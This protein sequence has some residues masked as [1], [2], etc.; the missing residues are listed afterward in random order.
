[1]KLEGGIYWEESIPV[2]EGGK[3]GIYLRCIYTPIKISK[4]EG[5]RGGGRAGNIE[6]QFRI[7][8]ED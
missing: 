5:G 2:V 1:M 7:P 6:I 8:K 4:W 3:W